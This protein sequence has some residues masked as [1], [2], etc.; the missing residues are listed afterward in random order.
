MQI[1]REE[2]RTGLLVVVSVAIITGVLLAIGAPGVFKPVNT[3]RIFFDNAGGL[4]QGAPV[5]LAGRKIGQVTNLFSPV[6]FDD[7]PPKHKDY[8][9]LVE[10]RVDRIAKVHREIHVRMLSYSL[11]GEQVIDFASGDPESNLAQNGD[12]FVGEREK[13]FTSAI[14]DAV[15]V[16]KNV[17]TPVAQQ[18]QQ[19]M[20]ELSATADNLQK[21]TAPGSNIDQTVV[22][23][24]EFGDNLVQI[25]GSD[26]IL[27]RS[28][29]NVEALTGPEGPL[30]QSLAN[31]DRITNELIKQDK[32]NK[33]LNNFQQASKQL[34][35]TLDN[36]GPRFDAIGQNLEQA[37]DTVK[38]QPWRLIWP[39]TKKYPAE[40]NIPIRRAEPVQTARR[41]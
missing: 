9:A 26:G 2:I 16:I 19:T 38:R 18:A 6:P 11:L 41:R 20:Q 14:T 33:T 17:V 31:I 22:R 3:Y 25:S 29:A 10:V 27:N 24:R 8:E 15:N 28:L 39:S 1:R 12:Y 34:S 40:N 5:M 13:D 7:R 21:L 35:V 32:I 37:T 4:K 36:L 30:H 23:F